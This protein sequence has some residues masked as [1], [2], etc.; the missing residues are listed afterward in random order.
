[1]DDVYIINYQ[2]TPIGSF[3]GDLSKLTA[4][5]L[6]SKCV[7]ELLNKS[8]INKDLID[9]IYCGNVY[10]SGLGQNPAR[11]IGYNNNIDAPAVTI[12]NVCSS[13]MEAIIQG[14]KSI[15]CNESKCV[16]VGGIE[17]MSNVPYINQNIRTNVKF[18]D[19]NLK[20]SLLHDGL[21]DAYSNKHMGVL[22]DELCKKHNITKEE[23]D[24]YAINSY[25][26]SKKTMENG[27]FKNELFNITIKNKE[28]DVV[29]SQDEEINKHSNFEKIKNM[30]PCFNKNGT[31]TPANASKLSD[32]AAFM[33]ICNKQIICDYDISPLSS[34][35]SF[36]TSSNNP[37]E[38]PLCPIISVNNICKNNNIDINN[39]D[40]FEINE[41][42]SCVP[43]L[44]SKETGVILEKINI[45]GGAVS[46]GH[47]IGCSGIRIVCTLLNIL[48]EENLNIGCASIC[49]G[50]GGASTIIIKKNIN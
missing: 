10:S 22:T 37:N 8:N 11:Q 2:R 39:I 28:N 3:M 26:K 27:K 38:F 19:I 41:A 24:N 32:G 45:Y 23:Q 17:S 31:I 20:D 4:V 50:G 9:K 47:P 5:E 29:I 25:I 49:N 18:G 16:L 33:L 48:K 12:N 21:I 40:V 1:M 36:D 35:L 15:Q 13:G 42:F 34:I 46:L 43:I 7:N 14:V 44:F 6:G 30:K